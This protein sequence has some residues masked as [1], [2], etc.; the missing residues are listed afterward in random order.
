MWIMWVVW[1]AVAVGAAIGELLTFD[2]FLACVAAAALLTAAT[3]S[4][5]PTEAQV[6]VFAVL[7][8]LGVTVV[9]PLAKGALGI[10]SHVSMSGPEKHMHLV[11]KRGVVTQTVNAAGGQIRIGQAEFW[12]ARAF[13]PEEEIPVGSA[14]EIEVVQGLTA[15]VAPVM[16]TPSLEAGT[17]LAA[18]K[19]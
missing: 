1:L 7:S 9:R 4:F 10:D 14:V 17:D 3:T 8:L 13:D 11:G 15:V 12:T 16:P 2:L 6:G 18:K 19:G 5:L